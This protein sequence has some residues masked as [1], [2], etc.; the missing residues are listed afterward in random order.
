MLVRNPNEKIDGAF[1]AQGR[2]GR[3]RVGSHQ[4]KGQRHRVGL[5][6]L[7]A[8]PHAKAKSA[9]AT[10]LATDP[11]QHLFRIDLSQLVRKYIG[12]TKKNLQRVFSAAEETGAVLFFD[13]AHALFGKRRARVQKSG[14]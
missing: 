5:I 2:R 12:E 1:L 4:V 10:V 3:L 7:F 14:V 11:N 9:A 6:A 8:G 13:E